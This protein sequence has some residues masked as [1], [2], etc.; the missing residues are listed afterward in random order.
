MMDEDCLYLNVWAPA[1]PE[2]KN[3][4][5]FVWYFGGGLQVSHPSEM[6]FDGERLARRDAYTPPTP[7]CRVF[8]DASPAGNRPAHG[9]HAL[10]DAAVLQSQGPL[11]MRKRLASPVEV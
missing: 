6:E 10:P 7:A 11:S 2:A 3:L 8:G 9:G 4:P 5:V 1:D